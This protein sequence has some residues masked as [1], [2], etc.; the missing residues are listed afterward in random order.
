MS[1]MAAALPPQHRPP[2]PEL[3]Q[4]DL[5]TGVS[6]EYV[7]AKS[8]GRCGPESTLP[9][10]VAKAAG[11]RRQLPI[12]CAGSSSIAFHASPMDVS[13]RAMAQSPP[14]HTNQT[15]AVTSDPEATGPLVRRATT[16]QRWPASLATLHRVAHLSD[17]TRSGGLKGARRRTNRG[18][19]KRG[20]EGASA[21]EGR[22]GHAGR[23]R[24]LPTRLECE[25][26]D[27]RRLLHNAEAGRARRTSRGGLLAW[28]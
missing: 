17:P 18:R 10:T 14:L 21:L 26:G 4:R 11:A 6:R 20:P 25:G 8:N 23:A 7:R 27:P 15:G 16:V 3:A 9:D 1:V 22:E 13:E 19:G 2:T 24:R 28:T 5:K 12:W